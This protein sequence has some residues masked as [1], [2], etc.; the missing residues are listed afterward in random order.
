MSSASSFALADSSQRALVEALHKYL[1]PGECAFAT[2]DHPPSHVELLRL[3][4]TL[5]KVAEA[6]FMV[7]E[8]GSPL[9]ISPSAPATNLLAPKFLRLSS[10]FEGLTVGDLA[11][12]PT[13]DLLGCAA[14][15]DRLF[16]RLF[17]A[18]KQELL[19]NVAATVNLISHR[20]AAA[21]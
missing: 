21:C 19:E 13:T 10:Y 11:V 3:S 9:F 17:V 7:K 16:M 15:H 6:N 2:L 20:T 18:D 5:V 12:V 4:K 1:P 14:P 8:R